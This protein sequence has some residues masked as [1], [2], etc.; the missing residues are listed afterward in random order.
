MS[1]IDAIRKA[2]VSSNASFFAGERTT[3]D[4]G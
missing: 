1:S 3:D 2:L 4:G